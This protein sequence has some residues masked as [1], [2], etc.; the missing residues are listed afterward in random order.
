MR[1]PAAEPR[2]TESVPQIIELVGKLL[3]N[4]HAYRADAL[5]FPAG[6]YTGFGDLSHRS[7]RSMLRKLREEEL[8]GEVGPRAKRDALD[9]PLWRPSGPGEPAWATP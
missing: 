4:G 6:S 1:P 5:Y 2:A 3:D 7:R 9:F 8:L